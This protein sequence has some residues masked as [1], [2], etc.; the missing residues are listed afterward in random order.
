MHTQKFNA[1]VAVLIKTL[2]EER[3]IRRCIES[4]LAAMSTMSGIVIVADSG[5]TD[6]TVL[7]ASQ[8]PVA[9]VQLANREERCCGVGA[10]LAY[11][12]TNA[13]FVYILDGDME[14][15]EGF[16]P[17]ALMFLEAN[18][19][20]AGVAGLVEEHGGGNYEFESRKAN[21]DGRMIG[22]QA[23][24]DMGGL[25][26]AGMIE[27]IGYLTNRNL[28]SYEEKE[29]GLRLAA[30]GFK[31]ERISIPAI[32]HFGKTDDSMA[33]IW[34]RW[35][36]R[37]I[38]G[39]GEWLRSRIGSR[40]FWTVLC[41]FKRLWFVFFLW[42]VLLV[43]LLVISFTPWLFILGAAL[44]LVLLSYFVMK[45]R[46]LGDG[47]VGYLNIS[48]FTAGMIRGFVR[49][50]RDPAQPIAARCLHAAVGRQS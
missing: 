37:H 44:Q 34:R 11:Q 38:D 3:N 28:H 20:H 35:L 46:S 45:R 30:A 27:A 16:L 41:Y 1:K 25:Y 15:I 50:Q 48:M 7:I 29:L 26:R 23:A 42:V 2:N 5:S 14:L 31:L 18:P 24:L 10:Q 19:S 17:Q 13:E 22:L 21:D 36:S 12:F 47:L 39:P 40:D 8:Y 6:E 49:R 9:V 32:R 33:L 43:G 4:A